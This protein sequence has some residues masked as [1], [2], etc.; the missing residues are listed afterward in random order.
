MWRCG[1]TQGR[2]LNSK[3]RLSG[4]N[5]YTGFA[6]QGVFILDFNVFLCG[7]IAAV[8]AAAGIQYHRSAKLTAVLFAL[9]GLFARLAWWRLR[10]VFMSFNSLR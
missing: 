8:M 5:I 7:H 6:R 3:R 1:L 10:G 9:F 4:V 2:R